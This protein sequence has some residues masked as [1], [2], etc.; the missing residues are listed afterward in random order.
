[1]HFTPIPF[2][3]GAVLLVLITIGGGS[4]AQ[5]TL[6]SAFAG[7][8]AERRIDRSQTMTAMQDW[9]EAS[10]AAALFMMDKYGPPAAVTEDM[11]VWGKTGRWKR[12][13]VYRTEVLHNFP[14]PHTDV[15]Q[16]WVD[17]KAPAETHDDLARYDGS[18]VVERTS[19]EIS[20]RCES[21]G[22]NF[23]ALNLADEIVT[24]KR[25]VSEARRMHGAQI[26]AMKATLPA[27]YTEKL[28]FA[29][30]EATQDP[31]QALAGRTRV[32]R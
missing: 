25:S 26:V 5:S 32:A 3:L 31:D 11:A 30:G 13:V 4:L 21:E 15:M 7:T 22:A 23:L 16:Q 18:V 8:P 27:P 6:T 2:A 28:R 12:T 1:M 10:R 24:G 9:P 17:Y 29:L 14:M 19:G 20:A